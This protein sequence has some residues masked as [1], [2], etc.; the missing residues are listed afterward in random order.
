MFDV[1][2]D[3]MKKKKKK[4]YKTIFNFSFEINYLLTKNA[5]DFIGNRKI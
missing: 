5:L 4:R 3:E 1:C 2:E